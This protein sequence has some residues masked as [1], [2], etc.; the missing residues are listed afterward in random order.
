MGSGTSCNPVRAIRSKD[1]SS[2]SATALRALAH[3]REYLASL[4][5]D[6]QVHCSAIEWVDVDEWRTGRV[7]LI[8]DAAHASSPLMGQGGCMAMEDACVL[9]ETLRSAAT[10]A[11]RS[12]TMSA[13]AS[14]E[15]N[16]SRAKALLRRKVCEC[17]QVSATPRCANGE[18]R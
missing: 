18:I 8:G 4:E 12:A 9:G 7:V 15:Q 16:G 3:V 13:G 2:A 11:M 10:L 17:R 1:D 5:R 14:L 6:E